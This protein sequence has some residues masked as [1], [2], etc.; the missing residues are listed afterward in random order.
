[1]YLLERII[2]VSLFLLILIIFVTI[3]FNSKKRNLNKILNIYL[4][5]IFI[6]A[7]LY[8][9][10]KDADLTRYI[11]ISKYY[12]TLSLSKLKSTIMNSALPVEII[13]LYLIGKTKIYALIPAISSLIFY[14]AVFRIIKRTYNY[15]NI[16]NKSIAYCL[17]LFMSLGNFMS[18]ISIIRSPIGFAIISLCFFSEFVEKKSFYKNLLLYV[19]AS[20]IHPSS[21]VVFIFRLFYQIFSKSKKSIYKIFDILFVALLLFVLYHYGFTNLEYMANKIGGYASGSS[22]FYIWE[23][24]ISLIFIIFS[25]LVYL[26]FKKYSF[27]NELRKYNNL[28]IMI[29]IIIIVFLYDYS[30]FTR[31]QLFSS[32][33]FIPIFAIFLDNIKYKNISKIFNFIF[34]ITLLIISIIIFTRGNISGYK[35]MILQ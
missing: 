15:Y 19:I 26:L 21:L 28:L 30:I 5:I 27:I 31:Y 17:L 9:P 16:S 14:G 12:N 11:E 34:I 3:I 22:Y 32:I 4:I 20:L 33:L 25:T 13:Y 18:S 8:I 7:F 10:S 6:L 23:Y 2:G 35:F 29:N 1:M 24:I